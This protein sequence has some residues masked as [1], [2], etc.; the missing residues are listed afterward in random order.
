MLPH[1]MKLVRYP[2]ERLKQLL[3]AT[4]RARKA[5]LY[6]EDVGASLVLDIIDGESTG[7]HMLD[8]LL[9]ACSGT[10]DSSVVQLYQEFHDATLGSA[11]HQVLIVQEAEHWY[12]YEPYILRTI[13][14][15]ELRFDAPLFNIDKQ[16]IG[17]PVERGYLV[18]RE[19]FG[20]GIVTDVA[21]FIEENLL[22]VGPLEN[23]HCRSPDAYS[24]TDGVAMVPSTAPSSVYVHPWNPTHLLERHGIDQHLYREIMHAWLI[25]KTKAVSI[26]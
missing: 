13:S 21:M 23:E 11:H 15:G 4:E 10:Y 19:V 20:N 12:E 18:W 25:Q 17:I 22:Y 9:V 16:L 1:M 26:P 24:T 6:C 2:P 5:R 8:F 3:W 7:N 14:V